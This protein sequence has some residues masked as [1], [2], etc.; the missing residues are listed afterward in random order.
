MVHV[1][2]PFF[3]AV[4]IIS[5]MVILSKTFCVKFKNISHNSRFLHK[6]GSEQFETV[7]K[8][9]KIIVLCLHLNWRDVIIKL[10]NL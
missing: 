5:S 2:P 9:N 1:T 10:Y 4:F 7:E 6:F 3:V 8:V